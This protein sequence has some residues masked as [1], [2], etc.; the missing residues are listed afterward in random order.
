VSF[1]SDYN[2]LEGRGCKLWLMFSNPVPCADAQVSALHVLKSIVNMKQMAAAAP[3]Y[4]MLNVGK[5]D[6]SLMPS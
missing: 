1:P 3:N 6:I 2:C 4:D 5:D